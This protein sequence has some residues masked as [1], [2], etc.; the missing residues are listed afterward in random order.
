MA[1]TYDNAGLAADGSGTSI[2]GSYTVG[3]GANRILFCGLTLA[4]SGDTLTSVT[5]NS[6]AM[7]QIGKKKDPTANIWRY[8]YY[9]IAPATGSNTLAATSSGAT[10]TFNAICSSYYGVKQ[11]AQPDSSATADATGTAT[12]T[13]NT[14]SVANNSWSIIYGGNFSTGLGAGSGTLRIDS[15]G[16]YGAIIDSNAGITPPGAT[17]LQITGGGGSYNWSAIIATFA[18]DTSP[19]YWVGGTGNWDAST[20]TN[21]SASS[22]GSGGATVPDNGTEAVYFNG[23]SGSGTTTITAQA[24]GIDIDFTGFTGTLAGS[25]ALAISGSLTLAS[26]MTNSYTGAIT[27]NSTSAGETITTATKS[28]ASDITFNGVGGAWTLQDALTTT[29]AVTLTNGTL[30][31]GNSNHSLASLA[32]SNSNTR[33][34]TLGTGTIT[35]TGTGTVWNLATTTN[36][37]FSGA[38]AT[39]KL[40]NAS[41][42][43][44]TFS[45][46]S[47]TY[48][49]LWITGAGTGAYTI[50]GSNTFT[51]FKVDTPPHTVNFTAG[52]T[53]TLTTFTVN[54]TAGNL[55]TLQSTSAGSAWYLVQATPSTITCDYL[56]LQD[57]HVS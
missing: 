24:Y 2:S 6:V 9:L 48:G 55:M 17:S 26:G 32:S 25:S 50:V 22:G 21:W 12:I 33:T 41:S 37:T 11:S 53:Q 38:S 7:T 39:V 45:G 20:T 40:T 23:S 35:L 28:L 13:G 10:T 46:G 57:S 1:I 52:S 3:T 5:Y 29:G 19:R 14:T 51:D 54:G 44:K 36:L 27:F 18:P 56:S 31:T 43:A 16:G 8:F 47:K 15:G 34:L 30:I 4:N 49:N 42:S